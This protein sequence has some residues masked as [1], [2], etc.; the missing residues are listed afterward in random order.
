MMKDTSS[1]TRLFLKLSTR[2]MWREASV[3]ALIAMELGWMVPVYRSLSRAAGELSRTTIF[4][5][6]AAILLLAYATTRL[7]SAFEIR[8][9]LRRGLSGV[10]LLMSALLS[11]KLLLSASGDPYEGT[12]VGR[13]LASFEDSESILPVEFQILVAAALLWLRGVL[14]G[15][16][17]IGP[18]YVIRSFQL[19]AGAFLFI[20][21]LNIR[22]WDGGLSLE[23]YLFLIAGMLAI[24]SAHSAS[25]GI[26]RG[27]GKL[28][29]NRMWV[30]SMI[31]L[32]ILVVGLSVGL[33][34]FASDALASPLAALVRVAASLLLLILLVLISPLLLALTLVL[35]GLLQRL[36]SLFDIQG[37]AQKLTEVLQALVGVLRDLAVFFSRFRRSLPDWNSLKPYLLWSVLLGLLALLLHRIGRGRSGNETWFEIEDQYGSLLEREGILKR[38]GEGLRRQ[39]REIGER[40]SSLR[41]GS[42]ILAAARIRRIYARM[43]VMA[44]SLDH[45]RRS[46]QTPRE[47]LP[48]LVA[49][50]PECEADIRRVTE[51]YNQ[52]RYG[53]LPETRWELEGVEEAWRRIR[54]QGRE[55]LKAAREARRATSSWT[56]LG[57]S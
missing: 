39:L 57:G 40:L 24:A 51:A 3:L 47:Y 29:F 37:L 41:L 32:A 35:P 56:D 28:A 11:V 17:W 44:A 15:Q 1:E 16:R 19:G 13:I 43:V 9:E 50:F 25:L 54:S 48:T 6:F 30:L 4:A 23:V 10:L 21:L 38:I 53:E 33:G 45:P 7:A 31:L 49:L 27:R 8:A 42:R 22:P 18:R 46:A 14:L 2:G 34:S 20:G 26:L 52:V 5:V 12:V 55:R 36:E